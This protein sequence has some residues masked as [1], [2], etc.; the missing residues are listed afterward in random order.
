MPLHSDNFL[1]FLNEDRARQRFCDVSVSVGG[2]VFSAHKVVLAHGSSYFH[3][4]LSK[5]PAAAH[6]TL[7]H[8]DHSIF[9]HLLGFLYTSECAVAETELP[10]LTEAARFL[11]M[12]DILMLLCEEGDVHP[13]G[14]IQAQAE[15]RRSPEVEATSS[16]SAAG[17]TDI[18]NPWDV[19]STVGREQIST[20]NSLKN[21]LVENQA[22]V[23]QEASSEK[24]RMTGQ[25][26]I[27]TRRSARRRKIPT[28]YQK[29]NVEYIVTTPGENHKTVSLPEQ[30]EDR[31]EEA[32]EVAVEKQMPV[33]DVN[34]TYKPCQ[35]DEAAGK[36]VEEGDMNND[37]AKLCAA[38]QSVAQ[39]GSDEEKTQHQS[40]PEVE[41]H[42][43]AAGSSNQCPVYPAGLAPVIIQTSSKKT[44]KCPKCDKTFDRAGES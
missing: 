3:A 23:Q 7:D 42:S 11:D 19:Q 35:G 22:G 28:K 1:R 30:G 26:S 13:V 32:G 6:V 41:A 8:V 37:V 16:D 2:S 5:N 10:A 18:Q 29:E 31:V 24:E 12:M 39:Q 44:L 36:D 4:E 40:V 21:H 20:E 17:D 27:T 15:R 14:V 43:S 25:R 38:D 9:Q 34:K 33:L